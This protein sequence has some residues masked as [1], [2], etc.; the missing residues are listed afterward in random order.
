MQGTKTKKILLVEDDQIS[1]RMYQNT[2]L[3]SGIECMWITNG[4]EALQKLN[5]F[6]PDLILLDVKLENSIDG[7]TVL[8]RIKKDKKFQKIPV[9]LLTNIWETKN[10]E[11]GIAIG[12]EEF[13]GKTTILPLDLVKKIKQRLTIN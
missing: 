5:F 4:E 13:I 2:F 3:V 6:S 12:A 1:G 10:K 9:W 11:K 8:E 7:F